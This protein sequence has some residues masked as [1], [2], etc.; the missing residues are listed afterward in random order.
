V[1]PVLWQLAGWGGG[2]I[3]PRAAGRDPGGRLQVS[4]RFTK[5]SCKLLP[6]LFSS[7]SFG[8]TTA[9]KSLELHELVGGQ[10]AA[11]KQ[12]HT[13]SLQGRLALAR[14]QIH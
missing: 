8:V 6:F 13:V 1:V 12:A 3:L 2:R 9:S 5:C 10:S 14:H 11:S 7:S 4:V